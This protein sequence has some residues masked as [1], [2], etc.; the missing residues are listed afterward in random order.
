MR[1]TV[2]LFDP[3]EQQW[4]A[5]VVEAPSQKHALEAAADRYPNCWPVAALTK[6]DLQDLAEATGGKPDITT[7]R[8]PYRQ[9]GA[10]GRSLRQT[11][12][13]SGSKGPLPCI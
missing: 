4:Y 2:M 11:A 6:K 5:P 13:R 8:S 12:R 7:G 9:I 1:F 3:D 10:A